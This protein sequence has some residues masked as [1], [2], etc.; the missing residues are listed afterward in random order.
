MTTEPDTLTCSRCGL[1]SPLLYLVDWQHRPIHYSHQRCIDALRDEL[2]SVRAREDD[3]LMMRPDITMM[4]AA[5]G[6]VATENATLTKKIATLTTE[7]DRMR[8]DRNACLV[9]LDMMGTERTTMRAELASLR[10]PR[11]V[12]DAQRDV[13]AEAYWS[14]R[15]SRVMVTAPEWMNLAPGGMQ[16][17]C[18]E[19]ADAVV[20]ALAAS[21]EP[22]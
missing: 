9:E 18:Y 10:A 15:R 5:Y 17:D 22:T 7:L 16:K 11:E 19:L 12:T 3:V 14:W 2:A 20:A 8:Q 1:D 13:I 6:I 21:T 4:R